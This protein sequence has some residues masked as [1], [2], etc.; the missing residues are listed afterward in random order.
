MSNER[1]AGI[2]RTVQAHLEML[3]TDSVAAWSRE[4][5]EGLAGEIAA[6]NART[7]MAYLA[8]DGELNIDPMIATLLQSGVA[9]AVPAVAP[10]GHEMQAVRLDSLDSSSMAVDRFGIRV[11]GNPV[12]M[13]PETLDL[14]VVPGMAFDPMGHRLGRGAGFYDRFLKSLP[15][16]TIR[17]GAC[18]AVQVLESI[19]TDSHDVQMDLVITER[20]V[21]RVH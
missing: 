6:L 10:V 12:I 2:R 8:V 7:V 3:D 13:A 20:D 9:V 21:H 1:K 17:V 18:F 14:V 4:V 5:S 15:E 16:H 11:P 19:P